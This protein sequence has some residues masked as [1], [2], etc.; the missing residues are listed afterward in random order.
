MPIV[1]LPAIW[2]IILIAGLPRLSETAYT[3]SL[4]DIASAF[5]ISVSMAEH[6]IGIYLLGF[7]I[8]ILFW[9]KI[10]DRLGRKPC[11]LIGFIIFII[12]CIGCYF[13]TTIE[14]LM[15]SRFIQAFGG[16]V[17]S[18]L[19]Q[20]MCRDV[21]HGS[22]LSKV[23]SLVGTALAIFPTIG[24]VAGGLIAQHFGW[25]NIFLFLIAGATVLTII[26]AI[27]LPETHLTA[28]RQAHSIFK[29]AFMLLK[30][31]KIIAYGLIVGVCN[32]IA[33]SYF[34][35]GPF[36]LINELGISPSKYGLS[37]IPIGI[38]TMIGGILS[39][40]LN[41][42][43]TSKIIM[44]YG[45]RITLASSLIFS[46]IAMIHYN[47]MLPR[48]MIIGTTIISQMG[49][50]FGI[51]MTN[52]NALALTLVDYKWCIGTA[53]SLFGFFYYTLVAIC[54]L[55]MGTLH[56]GTLLPMPLYFLGL[57]IIMLAAN[58]LA[59]RN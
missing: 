21:F 18:V 41:Q 33:F 22:E 6:T 40:R 49:I 1:T 9:G 44:T 34:S 27:K 5:Q 16:S 17:G 13:A 14:I 19:A 46:V 15:L 23:Y 2:L 4:P 35:E 20:T 11:V 7:A 59:L 30:D 42:R 43:Y 39:R 48:Y 58:K 10:S 52:S 51:C 36:Y 55:G 25:S 38:S 56:N 26:V 57:S 32:G 24:P 31:K 50:M 54:A 8:G 28:N 47:V 29:I 45:L 37:F 3:P 53:S 12:G